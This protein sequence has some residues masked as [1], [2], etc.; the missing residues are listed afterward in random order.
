M[1]PFGE[2]LI[3]LESYGARQFSL[4]LIEAVKVVRSQFESC[5]NMQQF[6]STGPQARR[7]STGQLAGSLKDLLGKRAQEKDPIAHVFLEVTQGCL[8]LRYR[9]FFPENSQ[10]HRIHDFQFAKDCD[11]ALTARGPHGLDGC[12]GI[13][14]RGVERDE[15]AGIRVD[16]QDRSRS[17]AISSAPLTANTASP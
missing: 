3:D 15:K 7:G 11:I 1:R 10:V 8:H 9:K 14:I 16:L 6:R 17:C 13:G 2:A 5:G 4:L 12:G